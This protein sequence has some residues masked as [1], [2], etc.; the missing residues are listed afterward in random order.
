MAIRAI[1]LDLDD[2]IVIEE[3]TARVSMRA[4]ASMAGEL[5]AK[6][7]EETV[8][9]CASA[10]WEAGP[11]HQLCADLGIVSWEG[12]WSN[13]DR[14]HPLLAGLAAWAPAYREEVWRVALGELGVA[15]HALA[16][17]VAEAF[18]EAQQSGHPLIAGAAVTV[19]SLAESFRLGLLTNGPADIQ[20]LKLD[21]TGLADCFDAVIIS[22]EIGVG[23]PAQ[24]GFTRVLSDLGVEPEEAVMVGDSWERDV[25]GALGAGLGAVWV[26]AGRAVPR[27]E[28]EVRVVS[29]IAELTPDWLESV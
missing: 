5:D 13:F 25:Q 6:R 28:P 9:S 29:S 2:T 10:S 11:Y 26:S 12:L 24:G 4:V 21:R 17:E 1:V 16:L 7:V 8:L 23:K 14:C 19:R 3:A 20:R 27:F 15:D 18:V 22:G